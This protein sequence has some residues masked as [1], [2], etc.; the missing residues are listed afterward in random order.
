MDVTRILFFVTLVLGFPILRAHSQVN[1]QR[2]QV[3][4]VSFQYRTNNNTDNRCLKWFPLSKKEKYT[5]QYD[6]KGEPFLIINIRARTEGDCTYSFSPMELVS[7]VPSA[8]QNQVFYDVKVIP[9]VTVVKVEGPNF[10]DDLVIEAPIKKFEDLGFFSFFAKSQVYF[11]TRYMQISTQN[12]DALESADVKFGKIPLFPVFGGFLALPLPYLTGVFVGFGMTQNLG[13]FVPQGTVPVQLSEM[14][15]DLRYSWTGRESWGRPTFAL[16]GDY[17]GRNLYQA[18]PTA[19]LKPFLSG[20]VT[21]VGA[22]ADLVWF[23]GG[24]L[25]PFDSFWSRFGTRLMGRYY[26]QFTL[27]GRP[28]SGFLGDVSLDYRISKKWAV[29]LGYSLATT[30]FQTPDLVEIDGISSIRE[31]FSAYFLRL[32]LVPF[33]EEKKGA[34]K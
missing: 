12:P 11:E 2:Y 33:V 18:A 1:I 14:A 28:L 26:P 25:A 24:T 8:S 3:E 13:N 6:E 16:V 17:R 34:P 32:S 7:E 22:G 9:P 29:G 23:W 20:A 4:R 15:F 27:G 19:E 5:L 10:Q 31:T 30:T 21:I